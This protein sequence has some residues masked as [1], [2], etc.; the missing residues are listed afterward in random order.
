M[1]HTS[2]GAR[3]NRKQPHFLLVLFR[4]YPFFL[5]PSSFFTLH[6]S[7]PSCAEYIRHSLVFS[8][9]KTSSTGLS[10]SFLG[11]ILHSPI[12]CFFQKMKAEMRKQKLT[13]HP[14]KKG[15][16]SPSGEMPQSDRQRPLPGEGMRINFL[17]QL[18]FIS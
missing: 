16:I 11:K 2:G 12:R 9:A 5:S 15:G 7:K 4:L 17:R 6:L 18:D 10:D 14:A 13:S 8:I 1:I 3:L